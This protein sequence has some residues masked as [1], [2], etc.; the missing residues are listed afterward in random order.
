MAMLPG[1]SMMTPSETLISVGVPQPSFA[2]GPIRKMPS[3][4]G[5]IAR[6]S[7]MI[8]G[9]LAM[10][11][12]GNRMLSIAPVRTPSTSASSAHRAVEAEQAADAEQREA[13]AELDAGAE[14]GG[15]D[16]QQREARR[17]VG[18]ASS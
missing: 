14:L 3:C 2:I 17:A 13:E 5:K 11:S 12:C 10:T 1:I 16:D 8:F 15:D 4:G 6:R 9:A 18:H 7:L